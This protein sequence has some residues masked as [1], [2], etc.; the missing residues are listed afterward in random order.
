[1][2]SGVNLT[3]WLELQYA[4]TP[5]THSVEGAAPPPARQAGR[6]GGIDSHGEGVWRAARRGVK[7][8]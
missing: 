5:D 7:I 1:M 4:A 2:G 3:F 8:Q 6:T